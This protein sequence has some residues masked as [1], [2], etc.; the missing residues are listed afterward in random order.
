MRLYVIGHAGQGWYKIG[1]SENPETR[2]VAIQTG[3]PLRVKIHVDVENDQAAELEQALHKHFADRRLEGEWFYLT[4]EQVAYIGRVAPGWTK[5]AWEQG[6]FPEFNT[7]L[8]TA[9]RAFL[10]EWFCEKYPDLV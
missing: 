7:A 4:R 1:I 3:C 10:G 9:W 6:E 2:V 8:E 5:E